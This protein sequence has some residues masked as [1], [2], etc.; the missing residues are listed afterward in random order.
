MPSKRVFSTTGHLLWL[1][2][3]WIGIFK[4]RLLRLLNDRASVLQA[5]Q[6]VHRPRKILLLLLFL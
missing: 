3:I 6:T 2:F 1:P 4:R 5:V